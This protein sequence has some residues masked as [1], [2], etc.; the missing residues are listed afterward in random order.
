M[1]CKICKSQFKTYYEELRSKDAPI[2][3]IFDESRKL[4]DSF[5]EQSLYR[6]F[7]NHYSINK[8]KVIPESLIC[9]IIISIF[10]DYLIV[11]FPNRVFVEK[12]KNSIEKHL[13]KAYWTSEKELYSDLKRMIGE[14]TEYMDLD[15]FN[16]NWKRAIN[17][18]NK[19]SPFEG[20]SFHEYFLTIIS[21]T[22]TTNPL[23]P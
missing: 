11:P 14:L 6:H 20:M 12:V 21:E 4:G 22:K 1:R 7:Q 2:P 3:R 8:T 5:S 13:S 19:C 15:T 10:K 18:P 9:Y 16:T 17:E 23:S